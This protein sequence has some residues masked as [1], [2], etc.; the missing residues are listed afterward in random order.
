MCG[1]FCGINCSIIN[2][3]TELQNV[4]I[5]RGPDYSS[6]ISIHYN[7]VHLEF[8]SSVLWQQGLSIS[9][10]P[11]EAGN[12]I[13]L[14]NGDIFNIPNE[15]HS[16]SDTEWL[17]KEVSKSKNEMD[18]CRL[19]QSL[20]GPFSLIIFNK[21]SGTLYVCRDILGRNSLIME[22]DDLKFRLMSTS[23]NFDEKGR[24][25]PSM[26]LP[27]LGLYTINVTSPMEWKLFPWKQTVHTASNEINNLKE[28]F[29]LNISIENC[30]QPNWLYSDIKT[31][32]YFNFYE[33]CR[34]L[35]TNC[36]NMFELLLENKVL[37]DELQRFSLLLEESVKNRVRYTPQWC[38]N[39]SSHKAVLSN[40]YIKDDDP[41][42]L[43]NVA[44][45]RLSSGL[46]NNWD[47]PDRLSAKNSFAE[48]KKLYPQRNW[49]YVEVNVSRQELYCNLQK[50]I[51]HLIF[52]L[53]TVLDET[54]G[55]AFWFA[56]R[57]KGICLGKEY[58]SSARVVLVGSGAD[59]LFGGYTRHRNAFSRFKGT[60][61]EKLETLREELDKDWSRI[62]ARNLGRDDRIVAD[63]GK[64]LRA[65][66]I[67]EH[68]VHYVRSF[69]PS[70]L[71][72]FLLKEG[73]GDKLFLR[74]Y[75]FQIGLKNIAYMKKRAI[76]FGSKIA[77]K[78][79]NATDRSIYL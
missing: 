53:N 59:E 63:N 23:Y 61:T 40:K 9:P 13:V 28:I 2:G 70:Q 71:C 65:P 72:C 36:D 3:S 57:G 8:A 16:M 42:D 20:E 15:L 45:E 25:Q 67:E 56:S 64:T 34:N 54:I 74:L 7:N 43:I 26:E 55:C 52:P 49:N 32:K 18:I 4:L 29:E 46:E 66:F 27:P 22:K 11:Y 69:S 44:F 12:F 51:K 39:C 6:S 38:I 41:I 77:N 10:Q 33:M 68:L 5:R 17:A 21:S 50:H 60:E 78:K 35:D 19:I 31:P 1:I 79:Q 37:L 58:L 73:V 62:W 14:F 24:E 76:Q 30:L 48:L 75:G 47:V